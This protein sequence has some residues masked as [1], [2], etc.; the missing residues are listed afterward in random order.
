MKQV[1][2]TTHRGV[3]RV[4]QGFATTGMALGALIVLAALAIWAIPALGGPATPSPFRIFQSGLI[5]AL[6][7]AGLNLLLRTRV[8]SLSSRPEAS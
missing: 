2:L 3:V 6:M 1:L 5:L 4:L 7:G 8:A